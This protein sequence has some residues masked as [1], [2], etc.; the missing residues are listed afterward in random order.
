MLVSRQLKL[1]ETDEKMSTEQRFE[2]T[3]NI[4]VCFIQ[5]SVV[6]EVAV[7]LSG[8]ERRRSVRRLLRIRRRRR[9]LFFRIIAPS[10]ECA[11]NA[12]NGFY[13]FLEERKE[14]RRIYEV[15]TFF[16]SWQPTAVCVQ[17]APWNHI[18]HFFFKDPHQPT[19]CSPARLLES[20]RPFPLCNK[21]RKRRR[22]RRNDQRG[23]LLLLCIVVQYSTNQTPLLNY[24]TLSLTNLTFELVLKY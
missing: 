12:T 3:R 20:N 4:V 18:L 16:Y 21:N 1:H 17:C 13:P 8:K 14:R 19:H 5:D 24:L 6:A 23:L 2:S 11:V 22:R 9:L 10:G 15:F 7:G